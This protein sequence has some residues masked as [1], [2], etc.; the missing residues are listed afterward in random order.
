MRR[1]RRSPTGSQ[2]ISFGNDRKKSKCNSKGTRII[3]CGSDPLVTIFVHT[4]L[5]E[6][7]HAKRG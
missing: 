4:E 5:Y 7:D 6:E 2:Q 3:D 1:R